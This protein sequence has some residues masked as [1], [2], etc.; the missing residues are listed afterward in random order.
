MND[1]ELYDS[2]TKQQVYEAYLSEHVSRKQLNKEVNE[3]RRQLKEFE[4]NLKRLLKSLS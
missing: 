3:L 2:W 4:W 1:K